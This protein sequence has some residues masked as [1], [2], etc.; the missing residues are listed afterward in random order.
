MAKVTITVE[1]TGGAPRLE[2]DFDPEF[3][4]DFPPTPA[5]RLT[6]DLLKVVEG[7]VASGAV[8]GEA[9]R[10]FLRLIEQGELR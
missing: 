4:T 5:Q 6:L 9:L 8:E 7:E 2:V 10:E 1:D 3:D